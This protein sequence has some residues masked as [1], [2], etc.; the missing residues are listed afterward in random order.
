MEEDETLGRKPGERLIEEDDLQKEETDF[1]RVWRE[2]IELLEKVK[3]KRNLS[4]FGPRRPLSWM[5][6]IREAKYDFSKLEENDNKFVLLKEVM[7]R[8]QA[9]KKMLNVGASEFVPSLGGIAEDGSGTG[10]MEGDDDPEVDAERN[11][12]IDTAEDSLPGDLSE[13]QGLR[14]NSDNDSDNLTLWYTDQVRKWYRH[15]V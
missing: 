14:A 2:P 1:C 7:I 15:A 11:M 13:E 3:G 6:A 9:P 12:E 5:Q 8:T 10:T 4:V